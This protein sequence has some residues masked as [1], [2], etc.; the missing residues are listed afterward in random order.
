[1][2]KQIKKFL[3][4]FDREKWKELFDFI[5]VYANKPGKNLFACDSFPDC[6]AQSP[7]G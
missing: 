5:V 7:S 6:S 2:Q 3:P 4:Y 1:M